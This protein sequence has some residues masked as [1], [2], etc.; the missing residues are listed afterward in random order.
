MIEEG[1]AFLR[2]GKKM[3]NKTVLNVLK[4]CQMLTFEIDL[5]SAD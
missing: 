4:T 3:K 1:N 5:P 2:R